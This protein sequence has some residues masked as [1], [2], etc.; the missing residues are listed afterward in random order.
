MTISPA[1]GPD[2]GRG[3]TSTARRD[4]EVAGPAGTGAA[5]TGSRATPTTA[6]S[7]FDLS[8]GRQATLSIA[9]P[10][11]AAVLAAGGMPGARVVAIGLVAAWAGFFAVFSLN[12]VLDR[13]VDAAALRAGKAE[14]DG[15]DLDAAFLRHPLAQG[16]LSLRLSLVW[17]AGLVLV[18][19]AGAWLLGPQCLG[20]F[21]VA[22]ALEV[23]YCGLRSVTWAKTIVSGVMVG[24]GGLAGWAAVAPLHWSALPVFVFLA[25]W[26]IGCRNLANDLA[27]LGPDRAVGIRT[28]ATTFGP[29]V[30][31]RANLAVATAVLLTVPFLGLSGWGLAA[32]LASGAFL[33]AWPAVRLYRDPSSARAGWYFNVASLYPVAVLLAAGGAWAAGRL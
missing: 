15:Y 18:A 9:Q 6:E 19:A 12:D 14:V 13:R 2:S 4:R 33:V 11:L 3:A 8:R 25:L 7:L 21:A 31:T 17:V 32:A 20:L 5:R 30:A 28:V 1:G 23:V 27:D 29:A 16:A 26:E 10:G 22:V 24:C